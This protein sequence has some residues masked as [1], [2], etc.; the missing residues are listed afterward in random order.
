MTAPRHSSWTKRNSKKVFVASQFFPFSF[1]PLH[2]YTIFISFGTLM[3]YALAFI[4]LFRS[5][6]FIYGCAKSIFTRNSTQ[7]IINCCAVNYILKL[8]FIYFFVCFRNIGE[9]YGYLRKKG[10]RIFSVVLCFLLF[11]LFCFV[12]KPQYFITSSVSGLSP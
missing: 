10:N 6:S 1:L 12:R 4:P 3:P 11:M 7:K 2:F 5:F 8:F 9:D